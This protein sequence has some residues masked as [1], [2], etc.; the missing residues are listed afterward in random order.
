MAVLTVRIF[1]DLLR[2]IFFLSF[3]G[4]WRSLNIDYL[5]QIY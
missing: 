5:P 2:E 1:I 3:K 4:R